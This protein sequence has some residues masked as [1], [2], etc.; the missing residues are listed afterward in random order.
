[1]N[2]YREIK[3]VSY[4]LQTFHE[5]ACRNYLNSGWCKEEFSQG[6]LE[7]VEGRHRFII[8]II[9]DDINVGDLPDEMQIYVK[10]HTYIDAINLN[11]RKDMELFRRK[12]LYTM[13]Q[14]PIGNYVVDMNDEYNPNVPAL[15]NRMFTYSNYN[16]REARL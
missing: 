1:M 5:Y 11:T 2:K 6:Q 9:L 16:Q 4:I 10:T 13:P 15:F 3:S 7:A 14:N 8:L 12:L